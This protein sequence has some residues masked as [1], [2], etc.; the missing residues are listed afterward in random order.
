MKQGLD[1]CYTNSVENNIASGALSIDISDHLPVFCILGKT[2]RKKKYDKCHKFRKIDDSKIEVFK[3][4]VLDADWSEVLNEDR[5]SVCFSR[6]YEK[7]LD[8]YNQ[9]FPVVIWKKRKRLENNG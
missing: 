2:V 3:Q 4:I 9:A 6:F 5:S 1:L 7:I 8:L